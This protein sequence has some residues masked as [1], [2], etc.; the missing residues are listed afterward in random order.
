MNNT[1]VKGL[2]VLESL[3]RCGRPAGV[4]ELAASLGMPKSGTHRLLQ[5]L[6]E[7]GYVVR[8]D[9]GGYAAS[10][11][12][13]E[14]GSAALS[15]FDLRRHA[16]P[17]MEGL[18]RHTDET[19]HLSVLDQREVVYVHKVDSANPVRAYTQIGGR[20]PAH[21]VATGK[22]M[23]AFKSAAWLEDAMRHLAP[24]TPRTLTDA[25]LFAA[26]MQK[27]RRN[28][29]AINRGEWRLSV[30]GLAA[31]ILDGAGAVIAAI[32]I[33]GPESRLKLARL[34]QLSG[35]VCDVAR[36]LSAEFGRASAHAS[37]LSV[38]KYWAPDR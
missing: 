10:I 28:G 30:N 19:V 35:G 31:P 37:L 8:H 18:M 16:D 2:Q 14:L 13:W 25:G 12:L 9:A 6:V 32:G 1:L 20:A 23:M 29:F 38:V 5:A 22:A 33:S 7:E 15:G 3:A 34:K 27:V 36:A 17:L 24:S 4:S 21:C 11:K 26:E